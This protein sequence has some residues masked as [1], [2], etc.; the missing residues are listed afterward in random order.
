MTAMTP[1]PQ[2]HSLM[3][4]WEAYKL[5]EEY[6]NSKHWAPSPQHIQGALW[7]VFSAG[8][9]AKTKSPRGAQT[10]YNL[11]PNMANA[12]AFDFLRVARESLASHRQRTPFAN[13]HL[14]ETAD[15][16]VESAE[17]ILALA[18]EKQRE[19]ARPVKDATE[20]KKRK[21]NETTTY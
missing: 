4:A 1:L 18:K 2:D 9:E 15:F 13:N 16:W 8:W 20:T 10:Q 14:V 6:T 5:T 19:G 3:Q 12:D 17:K 11:E 21:P 7:A